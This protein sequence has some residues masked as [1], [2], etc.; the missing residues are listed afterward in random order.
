MLATNVKSSV[1]YQKSLGCLLGGLI[2]DAVGTPAEG[3]DYRVLGEKFGWIDDFTSD[4]TDDTVMKNLLAEALIRTDGYATLD[5]WGAT[6][7][8]HWEA[9]F[10]PK[11]N[12]FFVSVIH[13]AH[14]MRRY[15]V[16]RM[17]ALGNM[18]SSSSAMCISPVGIVNAGNPRQAALQTYT[19]APLIHQHDVGFC[20]DGAV[21][22]AAAVAEACKADATVESIL[23]AAIAYIMKLSGREM[24]DAI[25]RA[26]SLARETADYKQFRAAVY[27][28]SD[29]F[30]CA[31]TCDSR[32]TV[33]L[34]LALFHLAQGDVEKCI[35]YGANFGRDA[36]TIASMCGAIGGALQG[37]S[38]IKPEWVAKV[39]QYTSQNQEDLA[40]RL[41]ETALKKLGSERAAQGALERIL[42][43]T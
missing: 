3:K 30:F 1:L 42:T 20:Q 2:G 41:V 26:V 39:N 35:T 24:L 10:G 32:E 8:D 14:K 4:G 6:W 19:L 43:E 12:K 15:A 22:M 28:Q 37:V 25:A 18:P 17:A 23:D 9:I 11:I 31:I 7:L 27:E 13:T 38:A 29:R 34:T 5:E 36:D 33:P 40:S 16:P 21:A